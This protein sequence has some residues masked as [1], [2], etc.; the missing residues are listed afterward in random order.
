M[1]S[2]VIA[3][4][5][6]FLELLFHLSTGLRGRPQMPV[7]SHCKVLDGGT[8][9]RERGREVWDSCGQDHSTGVKE[10]FLFMVCKLLIS[11]D[12]ISGSE[13]WV[14]DAH[15]TQGHK[16]SNNLE[17]ATKW[18]YCGLTLCVCPE[19]FWKRHACRQNSKTFRYSSRMD[20]ACRGHSWVLLICAFAKREPCKPPFS[21]AA[22]KNSVTGN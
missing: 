6:C 21:K 9:E 12:H 15:V 22:W 17:A 5:P 2:V 10:F 18:K 20:P 8:T 11:G 16:S 14:V 19:Q 13:S 3:T 1:E 7:V 4:A